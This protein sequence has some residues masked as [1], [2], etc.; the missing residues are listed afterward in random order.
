[1]RHSHNGIEY[2]DVKKDLTRGGRYLYMLTR[3][4][5]FEVKLNRKQR[6]ALNNWTRYQKHQFPLSSA[7]FE[8]QRSED[9]KS[10]QFTVFIAYAWDGPSGIARN[11]EN[12]MRGSLYHDVFYQSFREGLLP[13]TLRPLADATM[14]KICRE[15]G[16]SCFRSWYCWMGVRIGAGFAAETGADPYTY[17]VLPF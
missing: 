8:I 10:L 11:T 17:S 15:D 14:R 1:M 12:F 4:H 13:Q 7:A 9:G 6:K 3:D 2:D 5:R 16:M